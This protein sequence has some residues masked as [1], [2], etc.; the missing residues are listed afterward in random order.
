M[1]GLSSSSVSAKRLYG[2]FLIVEVLGGD[3]LLAAAP[4]FIAKYDLSIAD[5][6]GV[7]LLFCFFKLE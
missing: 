4:V 2:L 6:G 1:L 5:L 7:A 3:V